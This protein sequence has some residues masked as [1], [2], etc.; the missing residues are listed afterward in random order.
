M[1]SISIASLITSLDVIAISWDLAS[2]IKT[3]NI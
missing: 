2:L 1:G 3:S